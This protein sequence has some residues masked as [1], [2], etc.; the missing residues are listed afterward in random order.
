MT[1]SHIHLFYYS[2]MV[3]RDIVTWSEGGC[4]VGVPYLHSRLQGFG[5][6]PAGGGCQSFVNPETYTELQNNK[7]NCYGSSQGPTMT[8]PVRGSEAEVS[9]L[10]GKPVP[11]LPPPLRPCLLTCLPHYTVTG[12][13]YLIV[14][15]RTW[16]MVVIQKYCTSPNQQDHPLSMTS[17]LEVSLL[18][19][20]TMRGR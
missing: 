18:I 6:G 2:W 13:V 19:S 8:L 10:W 9:W 16:E 5:R 7:Q 3:W 4:K 11:H 1:L 15:Y 17:S 20:P 14:N 12:I